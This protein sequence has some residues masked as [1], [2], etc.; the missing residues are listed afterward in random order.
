MSDVEQLQS[1]PDK[2]ADRTGFAATAAWAIIATGLVLIFVSFSSVVGSF[3]PDARWYLAAAGIAMFVFGALVRSGNP[4]FGMLVALVMIGGASQLYVTEP[5]WYPKLW[6]PPRSNVHFAMYCIVGLQGIVSAAALVRCCSFAAVRRFID[7]FGGLRLA[8]FFLLSAALSFPIVDFLRLEELNKFSVQIAAGGA[9]VLINFA[10]LTALAVLAPRAVTIP[11]GEAWLWACAGLFLALST[12]MVWLVFERIPHVHDESAYMFQARTF[13]GGALSVPSLP[14]A[15]QGAFEQYLIDPHDG[16][17]IS[18]FTPGWPAVLAIGVLVGVPW[19]VNSILGVIALFLAYAILLRF[20][21]PRTAAVAVMLMALSPWFVAMSA[22]LMSHNLALVLVLGAW[23]LLLLAEHRPF[24]P[25]T[26]L[27]LVAG[28]AMGWCLLTR[29]LDGLIIGVVTGVF[30]LFYSNGTRRIAV[31]GGYSLGSIV[32][33]GL[34]LAYNKQI[35]GDPL[36]TPLSDYYDRIWGAGSNDLAFGKNIGSPE[37]W[38]LFELWPNEHSLAEALFNSLGSASITNIDFLG[39]GIGSLALV[40]AFLLWGQKS[41]FDWFLIAVALATIIGH[42]FYWF[43]A[44]T[45]VGARYWFMIL[46]PLVFMS[47]R[48]VDAVE[49]RLRSVGFSGIRAG[50]NAVLIVLC[51]YSV[52]VFLSYRAVTKYSGL[53]GYDDHFRHLA[54]PATAGEIAPLVIV[55]PSRRHESA[56]YFNDPWFPEDRPIFAISRG[57]AGNAG[58]VAAFPGRPVIYYDQASGTFSLQ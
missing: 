52:V 12:T 36:K 20:S 33:G 19:V 9:L 21:Q 24:G 40:W 47:A 43:A 30:L 49:M 42:M 7:A 28:L 58:V 29:N 37:G 22:S 45:Y 18:T 27:A 15:A 16:R 3:E 48:G 46:F 55:A 32:S 4:I 31:V 41:R 25:A 23:L 26:G 57:P 10:N 17:W 39:W 35:T 5:F 56:L 51:L 1:G 34:I 54:L 53:K 6:L 38:G 13:A 11:D 14:Q 2:P 44:N 8:A 50:L